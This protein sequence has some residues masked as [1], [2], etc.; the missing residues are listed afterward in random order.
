MIGNNRRP[1]HLTTRAGSDAAVICKAWLWWRGTLFSLVSV[2]I[3]SLD[4]ASVCLREE[5]KG[6]GWGGVQS[7]RGERGGERES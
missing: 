2:G 6:E 4:F 7:H 1:Y 3:S 5:E